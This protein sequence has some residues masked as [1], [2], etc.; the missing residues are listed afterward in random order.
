M[1]DLPQIIYAA[2]EFI[3][4]W[5]ASDIIPMKVRENQ[6]MQLTAFKN[7]NQKQN[8]LRRH[9]SCANVRK[10]KNGHPPSWFPSESYPNPAN[11][12]VIYSVG[13]NVVMYVVF[14]AWGFT[15]PWR[16]TVAVPVTVW[17]PESD[18]LC[19]VWLCE[20]WYM[21]S[22]CSLTEAWIPL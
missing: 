3:L 17:L 12:C 14:V 2:I 18:A 5:D 11:L 8:C 15:F 22:G 9:L 16:L 20:V 13:P 1:M 7:G 6:H 21:L 4:Y 10:Y 19:S